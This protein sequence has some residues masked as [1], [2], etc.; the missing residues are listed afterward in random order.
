MTA[1][2]VCKR[3]GLKKM[4][5]AEM[6]VGRSAFGCTVNAQKREIYVAGGMSDGSLISS[7]ERFEHYLNRW[8]KLPDLNEKKAAASLCVLAS[9]WLYCF[10]GYIFDQ[11]SGHFLLNRIEMLSLVGNLEQWIVLN[12]KL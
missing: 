12:T 3:A 10:G 8:T 5:M 1:V 4:D 9:R 7:C 2:K 11:T 6:H